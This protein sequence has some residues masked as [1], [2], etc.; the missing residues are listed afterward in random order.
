MKIPY[1]LR[2]SPFESRVPAVRPQIPTVV[3]A[4][5][6]RRKILIGSISLQLFFY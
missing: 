4:V 1:Q 2:H 3:D 5:A 6:P